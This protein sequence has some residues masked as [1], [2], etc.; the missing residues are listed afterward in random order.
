MKAF[1]HRIN[2]LAAVRSACTEKLIEIVHV[3]SGNQTVDFGTKL[4]GP[5]RPPC[6]GMDHGHIS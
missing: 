3:D 4:L 1:K 6:C 5:T 2:T